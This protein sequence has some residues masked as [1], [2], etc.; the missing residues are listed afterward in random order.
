M[1]LKDWQKRISLGASGADRWLHC[2]TSAALT[3]QNP[4]VKQL[5][6]STFAS[7]GTDAHTVAEYELKKVLGENTSRP[8]GEAYTDEMF[9]YGKAYA[10]YVANLTEL[11]E[12]PNIIHGVEVSTT[13]DH[14]P[15]VRGIADYIGI[16]PDSKTA[17][18]IDYKYG[19]GV[20]V[21]AEGNLQL[22]T[23][24]VA[25]RETAAVMGYTVERFIV[26]IYQPRVFQGIN[27]HLYT[28]E[29]VDAHRSRVIA[30]NASV[31]RGDTSQIAWEATV[32]GCRFCPVK[33][34]CPKYINVNE[35]KEIMEK[36]DSY[37]DF[38][39]LPM[40][41]LEEVFTL[42][43]KAEDYR[44]KAEAALRSRYM[45]GEEGVTMK[46]V[47]GYNYTDSEALKSFVEE[48]L[49]TGE[50]EEDQV[51]KPRAMQS[52]TAIAKLLD[53]EG[54]KELNGLPKSPGAPRLVGVDDKG[55]PLVQEKAENV[56]SKI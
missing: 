7:E 22:L 10:E 30:A 1:K 17:Y 31:L 21:P 13:Y 6:N 24:A 50:L 16:D 28:W 8:E 20:A 53:A 55:A 15:N 51:F 56:F 32:K 12:S 44:K 26:A 38:E 18:I 2:G 42:A 45:S 4:W 49:M 5:N 35:V 23:Y 48:K 40:A 27:S 3:A 34:W 54:K 14:A 33:M 29:E 37:N 41:E 25:A 19:A 52:K 47:A 46:L 11:K 43:K 39:T 9:E 36:L